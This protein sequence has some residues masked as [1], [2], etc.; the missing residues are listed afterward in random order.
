MTVSST[1]PGKPQKG[2][3]ICLLKLLQ[4]EYAGLLG[5]QSPPEALTFPDTQLSFMDS[6]LYSC[7]LAQRY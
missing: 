2:L 6:T 1:E 5:F 7:L 4:E 3:W